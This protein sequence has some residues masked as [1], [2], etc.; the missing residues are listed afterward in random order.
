MDLINADARPSVRGNPDYF[1]GTVWIDEIAGGDAP[2][3][4]RAFRVAFEPGAR[5]AWH[6]H[7]KGQVLHVVSGI[8]RAQCEG[9]RI[10]SLRPGDTVRIPPGERHWHGAAPDHAM[11]HLA[12]QEADDSGS[13]SA[14]LQQVT[15]AEY[16][17]NR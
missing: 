4:L 3:R 15:D 7:P 9:D 12:L 2:G 14:W 8:G 13:H 17:S 1:T 6:T 10:L 16:G 11:T 5:T